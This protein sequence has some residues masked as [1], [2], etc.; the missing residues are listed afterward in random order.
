MH[1]LLIHHNLLN[2]LFLEDV[3]RMFRQRGWGFVDAS[4]AFK[5]DVFSQS[6]DI[7]PAGES[8]IWALAK[9]TGRYEDVLRYPGEDLIYERDAM[10][11][12]G[13]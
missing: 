4:E 11:R 12:L 7:V 13:L 10:D 9:Q 3:L 1:T 5:D 2:A 8:I 6:P